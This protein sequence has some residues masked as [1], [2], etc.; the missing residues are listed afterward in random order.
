[1]LERL[2]RF[3]PGERVQ[4]SKRGYFRT[5]NNDSSEVTRLDR[6][7][8]IDARSASVGVDPAR[9]SGGR[10]EHRS[11]SRNSIRVH[12]SNV[13]DSRTTPASHLRH[14]TINPQPSTTS[15]HRRTLARPFSEISSVARRTQ[16]A[17]HTVA[18]RLQ[19]TATFPARI[20]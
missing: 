10:S 19:R 15:R 5:F 18:E 17:L 4:T 12:N 1:M 11:A 3:R 16:N 8:Q 20:Y 6:I 14:S 13:L 9:V 7:H 2:V